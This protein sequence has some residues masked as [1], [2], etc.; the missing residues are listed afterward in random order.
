LPFS[1]WVEPSWSLAMEGNIGEPP[2]RATRW[3]I[4]GT[5]EN[6]CDE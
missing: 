4:Q 3:R 1:V 5:K 2:E 6:P